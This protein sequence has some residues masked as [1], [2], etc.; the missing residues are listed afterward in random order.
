MTTS[1]RDHDLLIRMLETQAEMRGMLKAV[2]DNQSKTDEKVERIG[3]RVTAL[4][5]D[6]AKQKGRLGLI[7]TLSG[8]VAGFGTGILVPV[9][10]AKMGI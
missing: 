5:M 8:T 1:D 4:E 3:S 7:G 2:L 10:R 9:I 6:A